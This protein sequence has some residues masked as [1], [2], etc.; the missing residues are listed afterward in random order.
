MKAETCFLL[1]PVLVAKWLTV[2]AFVMTFAIEP[3]PLRVWW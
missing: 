2:A 3:P 1:R